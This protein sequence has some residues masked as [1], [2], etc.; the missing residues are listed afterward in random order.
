[1]TEYLQCRSC[2]FIMNKKNALDICP[3]CGAGSKAFW[4]YKY[5]VSDRRKSLMLINIHPLFLHIP[6]TAT[7]LIPILILL[8][9][10]ASFR[11]QIKLIFTAE[12]L[13]YILPFAVLVSFILGIFDAKNRFRKVKTPALKKKIVLGA[14][15]FIITSAMPI[16]V[17]TASMGAAAPS[18]IILSIVS[19]FIET[20]L[21]KTGFKL[22]Y[23]HIPG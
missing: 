20:V 9:Y 11:L 13:V 16:N 6:M 10:I 19:L 22:R 3:A 12:I 18:L 23:A 14:A 21:V 15:L 2:C 1:M 7:T 17:L 8:S 5:N 4:N